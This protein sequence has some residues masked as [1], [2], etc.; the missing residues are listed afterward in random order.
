MEEQSH[1]RC[2]ELI[3]VIVDQGMGHKIISSAKKQ[4]ILGG[5]T[6]LA[7]GTVNNKV[8]DFMGLSRIKKEIIYMLADEERAHEAMEALNHELEFD[9]PNHGIAFSTTIATTMGTRIY[10]CDNTTDQR[11]EET[12]H[13]VMTIIVDKGMAE[14]VIDAAVLAGSKGGTIISGRGSGIH[15]KGK[16]FSMDI[17]PEKEVVIILCE[18]DQTDAIASSIREHLEIDK[19]GNGIMYIQDINKTYGLLK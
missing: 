6:T 5:T 19:P 10:A 7:Q 9:K 16:L 8:L 11:G 4:G 17:E 3:C 13:Q 12:M 18:I 15:E 2:I 14:H 1:N